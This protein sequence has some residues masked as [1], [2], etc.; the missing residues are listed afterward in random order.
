MPTDGVA[1]R[2]CGVQSE[3]EEYDLSSSLTP[4]QSRLEALRQKGLFDL[5]EVAETTDKHGNI[6]LSI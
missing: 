5:N 2:I 6:S 1:V 4:I 3:A